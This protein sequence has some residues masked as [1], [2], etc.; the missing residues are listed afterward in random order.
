MKHNIYY[1]LVD[2]ELCHVRIHLDLWPLTKYQAS[3]TVESFFLKG[4]MFVNCENFAGPWEHNWVG[5]RFVAL[6]CR[7]IHIFVKCLW[8]HKFVGKGYPQNPLNWSPMHNGNYRVLAVK[9]KA[10]TNIAV[11]LTYLLNIIAILDLWNL[12]YLCQIQAYIFSWNFKTDANGDIF[13]SWHT[14]TSKYRYK[15]FWNLLIFYKNG[16]SQCKWGGLCGHLSIL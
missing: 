1:I 15:G 8:R 12:T 6:Q 16:S 14:N 3:I 2:N 10:K 9:D 5:N 11:K 4:P 7:I 13:C